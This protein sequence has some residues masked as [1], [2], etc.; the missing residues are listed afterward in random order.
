MGSIKQMFASK[1]G[2]KSK[3]NSLHS[4]SVISLRKEGSSERLTSGNGLQIDE[5][6]P[7]HGEIPHSGHESQDH[8]REE[9]MISSQH[10]GTFG[11]LDTSN[12]QTTKQARRGSRMMGMETLQRILRHS[13]RDKLRQAE[14]EAEIPVREGSPG[15]VT[16]N[17]SRT[18]SWNQ[19][20]AGDLPSRRL[21]KA[22]TSMKGASASISDVAFRPIDWVELPT[23]ELAQGPLTPRRD[24]QISCPEHKCGEA[25]QEQ[26]T[27]SWSPVCEGSDSTQNLTDERPISPSTKQNLAQEE[28]KHP[29]KY[30]G[31]YNSDNA[32]TTPLGSEAIAIRMISVS[33]RL[34]QVRIR[35]DELDDMASSAGKG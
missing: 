14:T 30:Y 4:E 20:S 3:S 11:S 34:V 16:Y 29:G 12:G 6:S 35:A 33:P 23:S 28:E 22:G 17:Y 25:G 18:L 10:T 2:G 5:S 7:P 15:A 27:R 1:S 31:P 21:S 24:D 32:P 13:S 8:G 26:P 19:A 9:A